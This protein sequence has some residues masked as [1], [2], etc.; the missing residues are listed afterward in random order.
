MDTNGS[1][2]ATFAAVTEV[3]D[4]FRDPEQLATLSFKALECV[5][6]GWWTLSQERIPAPWTR[7]S[8]ET[9]EPSARQLASCSVASGRMSKVLR[10]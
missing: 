9:D 8:G 6:L 7:W 5:T 4:T 3:V 10:T 1:G 2:N